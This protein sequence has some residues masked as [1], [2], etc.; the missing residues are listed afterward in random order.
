[1]S[2]AFNAD[3]V[4]AIAEQIERNGMVF[5]EKAAERFRGDEK[6]TL[7]RLADMEVTHQQVFAAMR[8][9]AIRCRSG[10]RRHST[11]MARPRVTWRPSRTARSSI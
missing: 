8:R 5:Y 1:M 6:R 11:R 4:L 2:M 7:L 10:A 3:E 9:R